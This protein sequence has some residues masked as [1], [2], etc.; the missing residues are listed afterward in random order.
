MSTSDPDLS[1]AGATLR[2]AADPEQ[3]IQMTDQNA[4]QIHHALTTA[5][6]MP[7]LPISPVTR[8]V[9]VSAYR[10]KLANEEG[11]AEEQYGTR[12]PF[13]AAATVGQDYDAED[14]QQ[15]EP[16]KRAVQALRESASPDNSRALVDEGIIG[17]AAPVPVDP[18]LFNVL[19]NAVPELNIIE[20]VAQP[21][22]EVKYNVI[23]DR[24]A[25]IGW[26]SET[27]AAGDLEDQFTPQS[28]TLADDTKQMKRLVGLFKVS[29]FSQ[30]A[31]TTLDYMDPRETT[32]GQGTIAHQKN[33]IKTMYYGDP[34]V[35]AG[36]QS[37]EDGDA[38]EGLAKIADDAGNSIDKSGV[39]SGFLED[40]LAELT[41]AVVNTGLTF[42]RARFMVSQQMYNELYEE[43]TPVVRLD[44]YDADVEYGPRGIS[45]ST[46]FGTAPIT[47][48]PNIQAYGGLSG[49]GSNASLGDVFLIDE[50]AIQFRQLA[51]MSTVPLGRTGL[52]DRVSMFEYVTLLDRSQGNHT[53][54]LQDYDL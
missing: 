39:S 3:N 45:L 21:G 17:D 18:V 50:L 38:F 11:F 13:V 2:E 36:D 33:K 34:S 9:P 10:R 23:S 25:P 27:E 16:T 30:R 8:G 48:T 40:L 5:W 22:F 44:G 20:T 14:T 15:G 1:N 32:L 46:E 24:D 7:S 42:D 26:L 28:F 4:E 29:D 53:F 54:W 31:M 49:V 51:P 41:D 52:A 6:G 47:P 37:V 19:N 12:Y 35:G 43:Q